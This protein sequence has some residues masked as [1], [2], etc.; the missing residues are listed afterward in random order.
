MTYRLWVNAE[1]TVLVR[2]WE[3][4][5]VEVATREHA[6]HTWGPSASLEEETTPARRPRPDYDP[7]VDWP[8]RY[9]D[10]PI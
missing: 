5:K 4:G 6:S 2:L 1:R 10:G 8:E 9:T 7:R 3:N